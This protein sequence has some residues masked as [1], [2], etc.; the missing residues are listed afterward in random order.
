MIEHTNFF[1]KGLP[2]N[3]TYF[4]DLR[5]K[6]PLADPEDIP[7]EDL[8]LLFNTSNIGIMFTMFSLDAKVVKEQ[9]QPAFIPPIKP[10][11]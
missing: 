10:I 1:V 8:D 4:D 9:A 5:S 3:D 7:L 2:I 6:R 11:A